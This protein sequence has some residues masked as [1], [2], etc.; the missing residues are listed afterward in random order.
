LIDHG[1][2]ADITMPDQMSPTSQ[3]LLACHRALW[4]KL[5]NKW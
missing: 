5:E 4:R 3:G 2:K 1:K